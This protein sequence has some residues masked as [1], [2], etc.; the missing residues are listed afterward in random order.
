MTLPA[1]GLAGTGSATA[2]AWPTHVAGDFGLLFVETE[3]ATITTPADWT[4]ITQCDHGLTSLAAFYRF[5][6]SAAETAPTLAGGFN[7]K[8]GVILTFTGVNTA[9]PYHALAVQPRGST[10]GQNLV[11][12]S[13]FLDDCMIVHGGSWGA[14]TAGPLSS[15]E[16]NA[17][18]GS[19]TER[20]DAGTITGNGGG[21]VVVTGT[22]ATRA[23]I[24]PTAI[25]LSSISMMA[26]VT[27]ALQAADKTLPTL[28]NKS[29]IVNAGM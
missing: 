10:T 9:T 5:A 8:W 13:T 22:L 18:L 11:G 23:S 6:T 21:I 12:T 29:R 19:V 4:L 15:G 24:G 2:P 17:A 26:T 7:H 16:T 3:S 27:I 14:D 1:F 25:T 20:Y 28:A